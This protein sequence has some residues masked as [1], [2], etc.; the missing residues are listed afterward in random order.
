MLHVQSAEL[1][2]QEDATEK[3]NQLVL[4]KNSKL[5]TNLQAFQQTLAVNPDVISRVVSFVGS[6]HVGKS[7]LLCHVLQVFFL[8]LNI[9]IY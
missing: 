7:T 2:S 1:S 4:V 8:P 5:E 9:S 6:T 3:D